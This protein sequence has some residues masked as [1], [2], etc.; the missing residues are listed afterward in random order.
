MF[1]SSD[2]SFPFSLV[3]PVIV[4][5]SIFNLGMSPVFLS[6]QLLVFFFFFL[7]LSIII[8]CLNSL[9]QNVT[10][11]FWD[12]FELLL[13]VALSR[14]CIAICQFLSHNYLVKIPDL[15]LLCFLVLDSLSANLFASSIK[16]VQ[17]KKEVLACLPM[18][19]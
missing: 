18:P 13:Y 6:V 5:Y 9:S 14:S 2:V 1:I 3:C 7:P 16:I 17:K 10:P 8:T 15:E 11:T 4:R 12:S 19:L